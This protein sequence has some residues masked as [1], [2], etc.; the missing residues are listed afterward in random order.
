VHD[1]HVPAL[2]KPAPYRTGL[3]CSKPRFHDSLL[4]AVA[5]RNLDLSRCRKSATRWHAAVNSLSRRTEPI[6]GFPAITGPSAEPKIPLPD[7]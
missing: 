6:P 5:D 4:G 1:L 3:L 7:C 2:F